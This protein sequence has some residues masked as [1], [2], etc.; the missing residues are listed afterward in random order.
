MKAGELLARLPGARLLGDPSAPIRGATHDSRRVRPGDLFA[1]LPGANHHGLIFL[2]E[3]LARGAAAVLTDREP[4]GEPRVPWIVSPEPRRHAALAALALAGDPQER[5]ALAAVTGTNGKST[6]VD[7]LVRCLDA[8]GLTAGSFGT[9]AY[10][11]PGRELPA[12]RTTPEM[13]DLAPLLARL[14][15]AGGQAAAM[16][17][18]S[19]A[20]A[21]ERVAGLSFRAA[22]F[23]N[24]SRD[25]LDYHGTMEAYFS[26][27]CRLF[28]EHMAAGGHRILNV[29][30]PWGARLAGEARPGDITYGLEG[31]AVTAREVRHDL[32]GTSFRLVLPGAAFPLATRLVGPHNLSNTLAAAG[33]ALAMGV[34][35][36]AI[37]A[38]L[39][40]A[41]PLPGRL[42]PVPAGLPFSVLVDYAHT[43]AGLR[44]VLGALRSA[45]AERVVVV[46]GA[47]G[48]RDRGKRAPMG[49]AVGELADVA[50]VTSDNPRSED[51]A[52]I[53][54]AVAAGVRSAGAEPLVELDRRRAI[55]RALEMARPGDVVLIAGK[56]HEQEQLVGDRRIPFD[57]RRV[58]LELAGG[59][60][61]A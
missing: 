2:A 52:A 24:L 5:L 18:S 14:V 1:A 20:L 41:P 45:G 3:A 28:E 54:E 36:A 40:G 25:H 30:D 4:E 50:V 37:R 42:E 43:P 29:D 11:V 57:D 19:H 49:A 8:G 53:A 35:P 55:A 13:T 38:G 16:E 61:C 27:K 44:A 15:E 48:D 51:P 9:L 10:R 56:G 46:F 7:L 26:A 22:V 58:V 60:P 59:V 33:A 21:Q 34:E 12:R 32:E 47:G 39:E 31:G 6:V 17:V 23:T